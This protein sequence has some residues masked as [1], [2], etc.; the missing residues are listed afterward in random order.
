MPKDSAA[1]QEL[2]QTLRRLNGDGTQA[3]EEPTSLPAPAS[4]PRTQAREPQANGRLLELHSNNQRPIKRFSS[5]HRVVIALHL[6]GCDN[7]EIAEATGY[8]PATVSAIICNPR[9]QEII[10]SALAR[11]DDKLS[12]LLP[13]SIDAIRRALRSG[14]HRHTLKAAELLLRT[15]GKLTPRDLGDTTAEDVIRRIL[16]VRHETPDGHTVEVNLGEQKG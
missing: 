8:A 11:C 4:G 13:Q 15:Q 3:G 2:R 16:Q 6:Q 14:D 1:L 9:S 5:R 7:Q 12:A 10:Q